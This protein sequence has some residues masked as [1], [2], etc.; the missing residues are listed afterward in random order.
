MAGLLGIIERNTWFTE[1]ART[2][3]AYLIL[4]GEISDIDVSDESEADVQSTINELAFECT[5][6]ILKYYREITWFIE[7]FCDRNPDLL[8]RDYSSTPAKML[9]AFRNDFPPE[10]VQG[11]YSMDNTQRLIP[12][13]L[14][15]NEA[16]EKLKML[17]RRGERF[18]EVL[19]HTYISPGDK[20]EYDITDA[21]GIRHSYYF[22][23]KKAAISALSVLL[24]PLLPAQQVRMLIEAAKRCA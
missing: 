8:K 9:A 17:P 11:E 2:F 19:Y 6:L 24:W 13:Y 14:K 22:E 15:I 16:V 21:L 1:E 20:T 18:Y 5:K 12:M 3:L 10:I 23:L 4:K 7:C